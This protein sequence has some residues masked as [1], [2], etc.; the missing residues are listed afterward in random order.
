MLKAHV[1]IDLN[2][3]LG[4]LITFYLRK[5]F[6]AYIYLRKKF[7]AYIFTTDLFFYVIKELKEICKVIDDFK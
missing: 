1:Q 3:L 5:K 4:Y 6:G 2:K 7:A